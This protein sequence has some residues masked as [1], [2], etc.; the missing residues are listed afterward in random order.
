MK[1]SIRGQDTKGRE[2]SSNEG[3]DELEIDAAYLKLINV[4]C[5][6]DTGAAPAKPNDP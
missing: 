3:M 1:V 5:M 6:F 4:P 2:V